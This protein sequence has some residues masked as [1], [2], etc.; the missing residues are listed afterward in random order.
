MSDATADI[1]TRQHGGWHIGNTVK[2]VEYGSLAVSSAILDH[3]M[4]YVFCVYCV[5]CGMS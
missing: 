3:H 2:S 1:R 4:I 5:G